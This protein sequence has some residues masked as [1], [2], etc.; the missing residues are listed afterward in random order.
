MFNLIFETGQDLLTMKFFQ[1]K[2]KINGSLLSTVVD[3]NNNEL[4]V[5]SFRAIRYPL[6]FIV[7][8]IE[9]SNCRKVRM[10]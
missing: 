6:S 5:Q 8:T 9:K 10:I 4:K 7:F 3:I 2:S 1:N